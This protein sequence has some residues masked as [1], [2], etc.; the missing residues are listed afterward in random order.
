MELF[1][2]SGVFGSNLN[3]MEG[4]GAVSQTQQAVLQHLPSL[5]R[6]ARALTGS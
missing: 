1:S 6:Y 5:R 2:R 3:T 4:E